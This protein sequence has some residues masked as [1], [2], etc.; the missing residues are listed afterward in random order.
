M[1]LKLAMILAAGL[2]LAG[3]ERLR[4]RVRPDP[5][6]PP[7][8]TFHP[9]GDLLANTGQGVEDWTIY[10]PDMVF[11]I[12]DQPAYLNSQVHN[13]GGGPVGG[14]QCDPANFAMPW[15]D[16]F[17]ERRS[18]DRGSFNCPTRR[19]HQGVDIRA[20]TPALC[21]QERRKPSREM[22][23][24]TIVAVADGFISN[25]GRYSVDLRSGGRVFRYIH[26]D[27][28]TVKVRTGDPVTR[29]QEIGYLS[30]A[31]GGS[32]TTMHLHFEIKQNMDA[33]GF[34]WVSPYASLV[35]AYARR[36]GGRAQALP[37]T[38]S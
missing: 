16:T 37:K 26:L 10:A 12:N 34:T 29:G 30:N 14:D 23:A 33:A 19:I 17:C 2:V 31:F 18:A 15:R 3:C 38:G 27:P 6:R 25:V 28:A 36:E 4:E 1:A 35:D 7:A 32:A 8:V 11:P 13:P 22:T 9:P 5:P 24:I 20:G 21:N